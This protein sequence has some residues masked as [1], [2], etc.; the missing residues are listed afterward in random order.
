METKNSA[1]SPAQSRPDI[2]IIPGRHAL[3]RRMLSS[4]RLAVLACCILGIALAWWLRAEGLLQPA[5]LL[6]YRQDHP[7]F[8]AAAFVGVYALSVLSTVPTL[9]LNLLAGA[10]WGPFLG[11]IIATL[12]MAL[13]ATIA[14]C[15]ARYLLG[16]PLARRFDNLFVTWLQKEFDAKGWRFVAFLRLN[17][18]FPT[19]PLNYVMGLTS[20]DATTYVWSTF[21]FLLPPAT[22]VAF[23]GSSMGSLMDESHLRGALSAALLLAVAVTLLVGARYGAKYFGYK[24]TYDHD[25]SR[26]HAE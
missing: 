20:I 16:Q 17:P 26:A 2:A 6:R 3:A 13:A 25:S 22:A 19:G 4:K 9:P 8:F 24:Q 7:V 18:V 1:D 10:L 11:G 14:F 15:S 5:A 12:C 23:I 21:V